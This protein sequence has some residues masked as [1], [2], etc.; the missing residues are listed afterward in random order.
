PLM[1]GENKAA[2]KQEAQAQ[3]QA[4]AQAKKEEPKAPPSDGTGGL[5]GLGDLGFNL[6]PDE[7][8]MMMKMKQAFDRMNQDSHS[9]NT[10]LILALKPHLSEKRRSRADEALQM[11]KM[12][13]MLPMLQELF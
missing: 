3:S 4:Q 5:G 11:M 7:L 8:K 10:N 13:D 12:M 1:G 9:E 2:P 6:G